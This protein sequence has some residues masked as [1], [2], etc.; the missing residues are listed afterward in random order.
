MQSADSS[1]CRQ[2]HLGELP[3]Q[4]NHR[5]RLIKNRIGDLHTDLSLISDAL[6]AQM[7][8]LWE[9]DGR[10]APPATLIL[11][12]E[13]TE[14][15]EQGQLQVPEGVTLVFTDD[16][17]APEQALPIPDYLWGPIEEAKVPTR[18]KR[19]KAL[20]YFDQLKTETVLKDSSGRWRIKSTLSRDG[21][22]FAEFSFWGAARVFP[23]DPVQSSGPVGR[24]GRAP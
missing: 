21:D 11:W 4:A 2:T 24:T 3:F 19:E 5:H 18:A 7:A 23:T 22:R 10:A 17:G 20:Q 12:L 15:I 9:V 16:S 14:L 13:G 1:S 6:A 8:I